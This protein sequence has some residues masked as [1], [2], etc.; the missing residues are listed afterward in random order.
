M[1]SKKFTREN[2]D[3]LQYECTWGWKKFHVKYNGADLPGIYTG[4]QL[5]DSVDLI[6]PTGEK[7]HLELKRRYGWSAAM[8]ILIEGKPVPGSDTHPRKEYN[9][10]VSA[11]FILAGLDFMFG[12]LSENRH[13]AIVP[14]IDGCITFILIII[15]MIRPSRWPLLLACLS[16]II[17]VAWIQQQ[18]MKNVV[19]GFF[20]SQS[21]RLVFIVIA[22]MAIEAL[23][24]WKKLEPSNHA[25]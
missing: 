9:R 20:T 11:M 4:R 1:G 24:K 5:Q 22:I 6:L 14:L 16:L 23:D 8:E 18:Q 10:A 25:L 15:A 21:W 12:V 19:D 3:V 2:G 17:D 7:L 13:I